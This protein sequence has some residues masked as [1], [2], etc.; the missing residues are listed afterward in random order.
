M[1]CREI[2]Q[3]VNH[4]TT[5]RNICHCPLCLLLMTKTSKNK[6]KSSGADKA[7]NKRSNVHKCDTSNSV[8]SMSTRSKTKKLLAQVRNTKCNESKLRNAIRIPIGKLSERNKTDRGS[9]NDRVLN[10]PKTTTR[11]VVE[12]QGKRRDKVTNRKKNT[13]KVRSLPSTTKAG[14]PVSTTKN[15][16]MTR[17]SGTTPRHAKAQGNIDQDLQLT[18]GLTK[19]NRKAKLNRKRTQVPVEKL[20]LKPTQVSRR[21]SANEEH[22][23]SESGDSSYVHNEASDSETDENCK[24]TGE[25]IVEDGVNN[26]V[27]L[28]F[29]PNGDIRED[30]LNIESNT[31]VVPNEGNINN[32]SKTTDSISRMT[33]SSKINK[34]INKAKQN[35]QRRMLTC[36]KKYAR[37]EGVDIKTIKK[38]L[39]AGELKYIER[40]NCKRNKGV[41]IE[42]N[43][44]KKLS[45]NNNAPKKSDDI[46]DDDIDKI[47]V[48]NIVSGINYHQILLTDEQF[49]RFLTKKSFILDNEEEIFSLS[50]K[51][52]HDDNEIGE[53]VQL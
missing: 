43:A 18:N 31:V 14:K 28:Q 22:N 48:S 1:N 40:D 39:K 9:K 47:H 3:H 49:K 30:G 7:D 42:M 2:G 13:V 10:E 53:L 44:L 25:T 5:F 36:I 20:T 15:V 11:E 19:S 34:P 46:L 33:L 29:L 16:T 21:K 50:T 8:T 35:R 4:H 41:I 23:E 27:V 26:A 24:T 32:E 6:R 52:E 38:S 51:K 12:K 37:K 17:K 45:S